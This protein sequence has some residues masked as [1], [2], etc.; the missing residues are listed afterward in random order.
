[1]KKKIALTTLGSLGDLHPM[2]GL[3]REL[4]QRN[5]EVTIATSRFHQPVIEGAGCRFHQVAPDLDPG[6]ARL[7]EAVLHV[8]RGPEILHKQYIFPALAQ[9]VADFLPLA[10]E[11]D[12][13]I[14]G[15]LAYYAS[16]CAELAGKPWVAG[17]LSPLSF[18]SAHDPPIL[19]P[20][21]WLGKLRFLGPTFHRFALKLLFKVSEPWARP[22]K[23][24]RKNLGLPQGGN[25]FVEGLY[26]PELVLA[27]FSQV[28]A[29]KQPDWPPQTKITG[30]ILY[31]RL[32]PEDALEPGLEEFLAAGEPPVIF[33]LGSTMVLSPGILF[34]TFLR[35][36][37]EL[38]R[39]AVIL[40]G[41]KFY[42]VHKNHQSRMLYVGSYAPYSLLMPRGACV[43]H[44]GGVGTTGQ[45]MASGR[46]MLVL[47]ACLDQFDNAARVQRLGLAQVLP[48]RRLT[49]AK[50]ARL[51]EELLAKPLYQ[52]R[53]GAVRAQ[54][55]AENGSKAAA[56]AVEETFGWRQSATETAA[57]L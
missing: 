17:L 48:Q 54:L 52:D 28:L 46:P 18:W 27:L 21:P 32:F 24:L 31:D 37:G 49:A 8:Q 34:D 7:V 36:A 41:P 22:V 47:P 19:A 56:D 29:Q 50:A 53:A 12:L 25:P 15:V 51:I 1:M 39:R 2:L 16:I 20:F 42:E 30:F 13:I 40:A 6:D 33:T 55:L 26:S 10:R 45:A 4:R 14:S 57:R 38:K 5:Y 11:S 44:Q 35:V 9:S 43:V 23:E 3:A